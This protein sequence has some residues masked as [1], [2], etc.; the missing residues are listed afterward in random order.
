MS[1]RD[2]LR[3]LVV[4]DTSTSRGLILQALDGFGVRHVEYA[5]DGEKALESLGRRPVHLIIS[6]YNMPNMDGLRLLHAVRSNAAT[7]KTGFLLISGRADDALLEAGKKLR[8]NNFLTKPFQP[9]DLRAA[10]ESVVGR[11]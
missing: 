10:V 9:S 4:D 3:V 2:K 1:V 5:E 11:L 6:D 8:M 7:A